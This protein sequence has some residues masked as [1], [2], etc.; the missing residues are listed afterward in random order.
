M[1]SYTISAYKA[2]NKKKLLV[3]LLVDYTKLED[4]LICLTSDSQGQAAVCI[5]L[6]LHHHEPAESGQ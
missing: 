5:T 3:N 2:S 1:Q 4:C 6:F